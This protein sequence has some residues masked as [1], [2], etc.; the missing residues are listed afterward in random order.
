MKE[1]FIGSLNSEARKRQQ[2][3]QGVNTELKY[4]TERHGLTLQPGLQLQIKR[5]AKR[6]VRR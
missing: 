5:E 2:E 1:A 3:K 6:G 4:Y